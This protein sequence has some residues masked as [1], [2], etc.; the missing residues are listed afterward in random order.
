M[1]DNLLLCVQTLLHWD[2]IA[3]IWLNGVHT[4]YWD[5]FMEMATGR[6]VWIPFYVSLVYAMYKYLGWKL[7]VVYLITALLLLVINDQASSSFIRPMVCRLRPANT[8]NPISTLIQI[9]DNYRGG[10]YGFPSAHAANCF[11]LASFMTYVFRKPFF[12][13][14]MCLW[15]LT[16][17][18]TRLYLGVHYVG[19]LL[20]GML[21]GVFTT[22]IVY[23][24][25]K[26]LVSRRIALPTPMHRTSWALYIPIATCIFSFLTMLL[27]AFF[28]D[29]NVD[30]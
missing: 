26:W 23:M 12:S 25:V 22:S 3:T 2:N 20:A 14:F 27:L 16:M 15:A 18:Y 8:D 9:V 19:D 30:L 21:L 24:F 29:P 28:V 6:F 1:I 17:C 10:A 13:V 11:G 5:N 4:S 7:S